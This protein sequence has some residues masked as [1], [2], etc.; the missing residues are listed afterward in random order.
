MYWLGSI[1]KTPFLISRFALG[2]TVR[3][4]RHVAFLQC[5]TEDRSSETTENATPVLCRFISSRNLPWTGDFMPKPLDLIYSWRLMYRVL[6]HTQSLYATCGRLLCF[7]A[8]ALSGPF[9]S[10]AVVATLLGSEKI[11][12]EGKHNAF[13]DLELFD[14]DFYAT[15]RESSGHFVPAVDQV[16]G[17]IRV[18]KSSDGINWISTSLLSGGANQDLRDPKLS[19]T[20]DGRLMLLSAAAPHASPLERQSKAWFSNDGGSWSAPVDVGD[21]N[22]WLWRQEWNNG[23]SYAIGYGD[24]TQPSP[25]HQ[26]RLYESTDGIS[27]STVLSELNPQLDTNEAGLLFRSDGSAVALVRRDDGGALIGVSDTTLTQWTWQD[28]GKFIGGPDLIE[29]PGGQ[30]IAASRIHDGAFVNSR[31]SLSLLDPEN[32]TLSEILELPSA[33]DNGY[34][35]LVWSDNQLWVSYHS[36]HDSPA[37]QIDVFVAQVGVTVVPEPSSYLAILALVGGVLWRFRCA[38]SARPVDVCQA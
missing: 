4:I 26:T 27:Y 7:V 1:R 31:T 19:V 30:I 35:G 34:P 9:A 33:S 38:N 2:E 32:G 29:L 5:V 22:Y 23:K 28:T 13:T 20:P 6:I 24:T 14:G 21:P 8:M 37:N 15:F 12:S 25:S 11:W 18:L 16:G 3:R 17:A 36:G 10:G